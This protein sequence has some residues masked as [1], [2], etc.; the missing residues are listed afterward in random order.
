MPAASNHSATSRL[1][2][3][4]PE[5]KNRS[6]PPN[7]SR[8]LRKTNRSATGYCAMSTADGRSPACRARDDLDPHIERPVEDPGF[9]AALSVTDRDDASVC[10][11]EDA[12]RGA[13]E[14]R[15]HDG[16]IV[17][18]HVDPSVDCGRKADLQRQREQHLAEDMR[19]RQPQVLQV[20][21]PQDAHRV[22]GGGLVGPGRVEQSHTLGPPGRA[23]G[24][25]EGGQ[26]VSSGCGDSVVNDRRLSG[27]Q[28]LA[29]PFQLG[30]GDHPVPVGCSVCGH[31][32]RDFRQLASVVAKLANLRVVLGENDSAA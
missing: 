9:D 16:E 26:A 14:C 23:R 20:I 1:R 6:R 30:E 32:F 22:D 4:D 17:D 21:G 3:A 8:I 12:R 31:H 29:K 15:P 2:A 18:N 11:L 5:M 10:L 27:D 19:Q 28:V 25:D 7:R 24:V 13:H